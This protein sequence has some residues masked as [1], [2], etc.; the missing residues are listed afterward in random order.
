MNMT[1]KQHIQATTNAAQRNQLDA[2]IRAWSDTS[3]MLTTATGAYAGHPLT[4]T[5]GAITNGTPEHQAWL[6][7]LSIV[8]RFN[9][10]T[11]RVVPAGSEAVTMSGG[12]K[13]NVSRR[14]NRMPHPELLNLVNTRGS[15]YRLAA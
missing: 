2:L 4:V 11:Y 6:D 5:F 14:R 12:G 8:E 7:K 10:R 13:G 3:T 15:G 1:L 9:G